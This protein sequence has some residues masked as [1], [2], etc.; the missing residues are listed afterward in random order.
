MVKA[1]RE[2]L[3]S[4]KRIYRS[5]Y[6]PDNVIVEFDFIDSAFKPDLKHIE[7]EYYAICLLHLQDKVINMV[8][9]HFN[10]HSKIPINAIG[11]FLT[12]NK[13]RRNAVHEIY[14]FYGCSGPVW[15]EL[16]FHHVK[17]TCLLNPIGGFLSIVIFTDSI[18]H[19]FWIIC[20]RVVPDQ[21]IQFNQI[22]LERIAPS[23]FNE[24]KNNWKQLI[25]RPISGSDGKRYFVDLNR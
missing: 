3:K 23:W 8:R 15:Y 14:E 9:K 4:N 7:P 12:A 5:Q 17:L 11:Q 6:Q 13:I 24:F 16:Q 20:T 18:D 25:M 21:I 19:L 10:M 22:H 2:K 1:I